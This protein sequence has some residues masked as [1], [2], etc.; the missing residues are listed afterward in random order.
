MKA[1]VRSAAIMA[2]YPSRRTLLRSF[3]ERFAQMP[4]GAEMKACVTMITDVSRGNCALD[5]TCKTVTLIDSTS[6]SV[7]D[8]CKIIPWLQTFTL[9]GPLSFKSEA[10]AL[11]KIRPMYSPVHDPALIILRMNV[12]I[13]NGVLNQ[14][15]AC[16]HSC[17]SPAVP[18]PSTSPGGALRLAQQQS[19]ARTVRHS[20][21]VKRR[22][23]RSFQ[24][25]TILCGR[26]G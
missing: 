24:L 21:S 13:A 8:L 11:P 7:A 20:Y 5:I 19:L 1:N 23:K 10:A 16:P 17:T 18:G 22:G 2:A 25:S 4:A 9:V 3:S 14:R 6:N 26:E 15:I 12:R